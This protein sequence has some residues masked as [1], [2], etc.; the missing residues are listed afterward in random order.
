MVSLTIQAQHSDKRNYTPERF[1]ADMEQYITRKAGLSPK[2][3]SRFFPLYSEMLDKQRSLREKI[4][5]LKR[6]KPKSAS[7]CKKNIQKID[8]MEIEIKKIQKSYHEKFIQILS[9]DKVY[10]IIK[11]EDRFHRQAVKNMASKMK[12][13]RN[14]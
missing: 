1:R 7:E 13:K 14:R 9:A 4:K 11:A 8:E 10:D 3:A 5:N 6:I 12:Q 2:D